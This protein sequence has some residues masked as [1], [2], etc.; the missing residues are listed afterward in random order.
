MG[1]AVVYV[2]LV[3]GICSTALLAGL[4]ATRLGRPGVPPGRRVEDVYEA[5]FLG[6]G[7]GR[8]VDV[9][10]TALHQDGRLLIGG[11][12]IV[13]ERRPVAGDAVERAVLDALAVAPNGSLER[14]RQTVMRDPVVQA[15][16]DRLAADGLMTAPTPGRRT[17]SGCGRALGL[18]TAWSIPAAVALNV[19]AFVREWERPEVPFAV[20]V[21]PALV[22]GQ[23][24]GFTVAS[25]ARAR[26][27]PAGKEA[28]AAHGAKHLATEAPPRLVAIKGARGV[29]DPALRTVLVA[30][31]LA[32]VVFV[33]A[34]GGASGAVAAPWCG[35]GAGAGCGSTSGD[36]ETAGDSGGDDSGGGS[37]GGSG[38]GGSG[39]DGGGGSGCGG[40][41]GCGCG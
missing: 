29:P 1:P 24:A 5:A 31:A 15:I 2:Y 17:L 33:A 34:A 16:G 3:M 27:T 6:G 12:G 35:S 11:P 25:R 40:C 32:P 4:L 26:I 36:S 30:A 20:L 38:D 22:L 10:L 14:L 39:G 9:A 37:D 28:L 18:V 23:V 7:P 41:G 19:V 8:V 21:L 13:S